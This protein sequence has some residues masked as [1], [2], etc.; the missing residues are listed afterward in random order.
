MATICI[1]INLSSRQLSRRSTERI[2]IHSTHASQRC[3]EQPIRPVP[4]SNSASTVFACRLRPGLT[5][6]LDHA[7]VLWLLLWRPLSPPFLQAKIPL[8]HIPAFSCSP[9]LSFDFMVTVTFDG[10]Q[11]LGNTRFSHR[12]N[13]HS[14]PQRAYFVY[15]ANLRIRDA[16]LFLFLIC[17]AIQYMSNLTKN[18][19]ACV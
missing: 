3:C 6:F 7:C 19:I 11:S 15:C 13:D 4:V 1:V 10:A 2:S 8:G 16:T 17:L 12:M 5:Q 14:Q 18:D 9:G